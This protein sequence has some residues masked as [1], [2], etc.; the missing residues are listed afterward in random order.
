[1][2]RLAS[3]GSVSEN[4]RERVVRLWRIVEIL[5]ASPQGVLREHLAAQIQV[6]RSTCYRDIDILK[7]AGVNVT[8]KKVGGSVRY[9]LNDHTL[10]PLRPTPRQI[11][12]LRLARTLLAPFEGMGVVRELDGLLSSPVEEQ[13]FPLSFASR[14]PPSAPQTLSQVEHALNTGKRLRFSYHSPT[15]DEVSTRTAD[16]VA[17]RAVEGHLYLVGFDIEKK[18]ARTFKLVRMTDLVVLRCKADPHPEIDQEA[19]FANS[20]KAWSGD[21]VEV[22]VQIPARLAAIAGEWPLVAGQEL[23][24]QGNGMALVTARVAGLIEAMRWVLRWGATATVVRPE[25]LRDLVVAEL[26]RALERYSSG[27][28][29]T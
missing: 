17:L 6:G 18:S 10:P 15:S 5:N 12:A 26:S 8:S 7:A 4:R 23:H 13:F 22:V 20:V 9:F 11:L 28:A 25:E 19:M 14:G 1:M 24:D 27:D 3:H 16:P 2:D 29:R 21:L